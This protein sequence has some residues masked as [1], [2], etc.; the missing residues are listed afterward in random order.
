MIAWPQFKRLLFQLSRKGTPLKP[1]Y[2][3]PYALR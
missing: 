3:K 1:V 2:P